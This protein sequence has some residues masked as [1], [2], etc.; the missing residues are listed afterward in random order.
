MGTEKNQHMNPDEAPMLPQNYRIR[1][2]SIGDRKGGIR[3]HHSTHARDHAVRAHFDIDK[4][5]G[6]TS[7]NT[8]RIL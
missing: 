8:K 1:P 2:D 6:L 7:I 5:N 4:I 3:A